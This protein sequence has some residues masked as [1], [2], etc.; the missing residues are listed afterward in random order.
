[1]TPSFNVTGIVLTLLS[2]FVALLAWLVVLIVGF[3]RW[4]HTRQYLRQGAILAVLTFLAGLPLLVVT[5]AYMDLSKSLPPALGPTFAR[6]VAIA[7]GIGGVVAALV[8]LAHSCLK[9]PVALLADPERCPFPLLLGRERRF[10]GWAVAAAWGTLLGL[11]SVAAFQY[12]GVEV[13]PMVNAIQ[14]LTPHLDRSALIY[15]VAVFLPA[16][17]GAAIAEEVVYR[18]LIQPWLARVIGGTTLTLVAANVITSALW[19]I[20]HSLNTNDMEAK[21]LQV[22]AIGLIFG[23]I[24]RRYSVEASMV[25][26]ALLNIFAVM[27]PLLL[28][29][30]GIVKPAVAPPVTQAEESEERPHPLPS[31]PES[32]TIALDEKPRV[33]WARRNLL[34]AYDHV[35]LKNPRWDA[36]VRRFIEDAIPDLID[37]HHSERVWAKD[38]VGRGREILSKG[39]DDPLFLYLQS[40][41][42]VMAE[43]FSRDSRLLCERAVE[44]MKTVRYPRAIARYVASGLYSDYQGANEVHGL[45]GRLAPLELQWFIESLGD[46]SYRSGEDGLLIW[47]LKNGTGEPFFERNKLPASAAVD[48]APRIERWAKLFVSGLKHYTLAWEARGHG[49]ANE[50]TPDGWRNFE[51]YLTLARRD[52]VEAWRLRPDR[53]EAAYEM[54]SV[55]EDA[56]EPGESGR[57]WF[58]RAVAARMDYWPA[59]N[60]RLN[61]LLPRWGGSH[62][63]MLDF[64]QECLDTERFDTFV[65]S[66][67]IHAVRRIE[68]DERD[69][70]GEG[71]GRVTVHDDPRTFPLVARALDGYL[72]EPSCAWERPRWLSLYAVFADKAGRHAVA[73]EKMQSAGMDLDSDAFWRIQESPRLFVS[74]VS[75]LGGAG[76]TEALQ[77]EQLRSA[78]EGEK[79]LLPLSGAMQRD[80]SRQS[81]FYFRT[82][83]VALSLERDLEGGAWL[84]FL[85]KD[86]DLSG[87]EIREGKWTIESDGALVATAGPRG[88][89]LVS[90]AHVGPDFELRGRMELVSSTNDSAQGGILFGHPA[91][92]TRDWISFR[93]MK[94]GYHMETTAL[95]AP[96]FTLPKPWLGVPAADRITFLVRS[97]KG[98][99]TGEVNGQVIARDY[100]PAK[101]F[102]NNRDAQVGFGAYHDDNECVVRYRNVEIRRLKAP[103]S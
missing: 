41:S 6:I 60:A 32:P 100:R 80:S 75:A 22:F 14:A 76:G 36:E 9:V 54:M 4:S 29:S 61:R 21:L 38:L 8:G 86:K 31:G 71:N 20:A 57:L 33:E 24:A 30:M 101:G 90:G 49:F 17:V 78:L 63:E 77:A 18:G 12:L 34:E 5:L 66:V 44:G 67:V 15:Q 94:N 64:G 50:V 25:S 26:H 102:V 47:Q 93:Y 81:A 39:C 16:T 19:A 84:P 96:G 68:D 82:R 79:A 91:L 69:N 53:P 73:F 11:V 13:N 3:V 56:P 46:G 87:W 45:R 92:E 95:F 7:G 103:P 52:L 28:V 27:T 1:M 98:L 42:L 85:P 40:R 99:L 10:D 72:K 2:S 58:D 89:I 23:V 83:L 74:R 55:A 37:V 43:G 88:T 59:Y 51:R 65:P 97:W 70:G 35:G 48:A 62:K